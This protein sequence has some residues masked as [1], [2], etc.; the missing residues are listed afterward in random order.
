MTAP[1]QTP[2]D[3]PV[4]GWRRL[5]ADALRQVEIAERARERH[6]GHTAAD[7][8]TAAVVSLRAAGASAGSVA[9]HRWLER[10]RRAVELRLTQFVP[11]QLQLL[12]EQTVL[13][14]RAGGRPPER[15]VLWI[16]DEGVLSSPQPLGNAFQERGLAVGVY[17]PDEGTLD[18][19]PFDILPSAPPATVVGVGREADRAARFAEAWSADLV[20]VVP[21]D[22]PV[23][24]PQAFSR[25]TL[26]VRPEQALTVAPAGGLGP[27]S[28]VQWV[29]SDR[30]TTG[31]GS[32]RWQH[33]FGAALADWIRDHQRG[34]PPREDRYLDLDES[35]LRHEPLANLPWLLP[36]TPGSRGR[37]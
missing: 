37:T 17:V 3:R 20:L 35:G 28:G 32:G 26:V 9:I 13:L 11:D 21:T 10:Q 7:L 8:L 18:R 12:A 14:T 1:A 23:E 2:A 29:L 33:D 25:A 22:P 5:A 24:A 4:D 36:E 30:L 15:W 6:H 16:G 27:Y 34:E 19:S 31:A